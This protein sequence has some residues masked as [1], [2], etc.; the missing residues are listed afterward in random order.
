MATHTLLLA[1]DSH[2]VQHVLEMALADEDV[3][4]VA[5]ADGTEAIARIRAHPPDIVLADIG[6][7]GQNGYDVAAFVKG[8]RDLAHIPV[9]LLA[10]M[11]EPADEAKARQSGCAEI[12]IKPLK[13]QHVVARVRHW[14]RSPLQRPA[15]DQGSEPATAASSNTPV[16][17]AGPQS[18]EDY[19]NRLDAAFKSLNRLGGR[20]SPPL[21]TAD[22]AD[23][24]TG[25][26]ASIPTL[27]ELLER[28]PSE[29]RTRLAAAPLSTGGEGQAPSDYTVLDNIATR[30]LEHLSRRGD[31]LDEIARRA[32]LLQKPDKER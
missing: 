23:S 18:A 9:V 1:D 3:D 29:T 21:G 6:M 19:F 30:V 16:A 20:Q 2:T 10:G 28:L 14:L 5:V 11:F 22:A 32:A 15:V 27:Q 7:P 26:A 13:P 8:R 25:G 17:S 31:L 12:L 4:V 24:P